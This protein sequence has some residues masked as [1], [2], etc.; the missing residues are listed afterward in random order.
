MVKKH[1]MASGDHTISGNPSEYYEMTSGSG[2]IGYPADDNSGR[3]T[4]GRIVK[5][6]LPYGGEPALYGVSIDY[7]NSN[8]DGI[9]NS[10]DSRGSKAQGVSSSSI[11]GGA[12]MRHPVSGTN[13][14]KP[15]QRK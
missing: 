9:R 7:P 12:P 15:I 5:Q 1:N 8:V 6:T 11:S 4:G 14:M 10:T 2:E 13:P 3:G